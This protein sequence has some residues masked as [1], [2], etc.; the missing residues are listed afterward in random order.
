MGCLPKSCGGPISS[1]LGKETAVKL[2]K[3]CGA[4]VLVGFLI[5][6]V[7]SWSANLVVGENIKPGMALSDAIKLLGIPAS[8]KIDRGPDPSRDS[9]QLSY[10]S[11]GLKIRAINGG[12][13]VEAIEIDPTFKGKFASGLKLGDKFT[14]IIKLY[15]TPKTIS[16]QVIRYPDH[17][18]Y[19][20]LSKDAL[21]SAKTFLKGTKLVQH[22]KM[23]P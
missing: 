12:T 13:Q 2:D 19:F 8:V 23:N 3:V 7:L 6:P 17:G 9:I 14:D 1:N 15:G 4:I 18:L 10:A 20:L 22:E 5:S 11:Q 16:S 21:L